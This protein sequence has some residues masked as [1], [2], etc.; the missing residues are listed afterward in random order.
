MC[1]IDYFS[2]FQDVF[3]YFSFTFLVFLFAVIDY[4]NHPSSVYGSQLLQTKK[5]SDFKYLDIL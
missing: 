5:K 2:S 4:R 3:S 1:F